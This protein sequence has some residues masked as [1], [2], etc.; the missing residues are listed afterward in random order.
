LIYFYSFQESKRRILEVQKQMEEDKA[1]EV[2][3]EVFILDFED[4][5]I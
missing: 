1:E 2:V 3:K 4:S 5:K